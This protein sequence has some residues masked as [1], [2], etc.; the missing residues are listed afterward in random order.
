MS[1]RAAIIGV[2]QTAYRRRHADKN[3][4]ELAREAMRLALDDAGLGLDAIGLVVGGVAPDT[5]AGLDH[6]DKAS[7]AR[8]GIPYMRVHTGGATGS[9]ALLA[10]LSWVAAGRCEAALVVAI[11]RMGQAETA[12]KIF[13]TIFDPIYEKDLALSTI[14]MAA[15]RA[16]MLMRRYGYRPE[17]WAGVA[18]RNSEAAGRNP[19]AP[20][21][22]VFTTEQVLASKMLCWPIRAYEVCPISEGACAVVVTA[23]R[24]ARGRNA[25]WVQGAHGQTD[26]YNMGDRVN[27][28]EG[29][30]VDLLTLQRSAR[31]AYA[32]AGISDPASEID[33]AEVQAPFPSAESMHY[34]GL[35][36]C[37]PEGGPAFVDRL[38]ADRVHV[39]INP[40]GGPQA[41]NPVSATAL[42]RVA[43]AAQ[44]VRGRAGPVQVDGVRRAIATGQGGASQFSTAIL[45]GRDRP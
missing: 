7:L 18:A 11:E 17:Q 12:Q 40:S 42:V 38:L 33:V 27:R 39:A 20:E 14:V 9:S 37:T 34:T 5:L 1:A 24:L 29:A 23:E 2:G 45:F 28:P 10:A 8:P 32:Q 15:L 25:A 41:A 26:S 13:N 43:E 21:A 44:Q 19:F 16:S 6:M 35:G 22:R 3:A 30:L 31:A 36:L 4:A